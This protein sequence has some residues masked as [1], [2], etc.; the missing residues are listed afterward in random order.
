MS[1]D[2]GNM[3]KRRSKLER[4]REQEESLITIAEGEPRIARVQ[5]AKKRLEATRRKIKEL[6]GE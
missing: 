6:T 2:I 4:L 1:E 3:P 5:Q